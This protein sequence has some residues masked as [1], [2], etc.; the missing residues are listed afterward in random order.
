MEYSR[1]ILTNKLQNNFQAFEREVD[2]LS[3]KDKEQIRWWSEK[4]FDYI[5]NTRS[6][7]KFMN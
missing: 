3:D 4:R 1:I 5:K 7:E 6:I 2:K